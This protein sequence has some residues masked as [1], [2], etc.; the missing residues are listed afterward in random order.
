MKK[1]L[2]LICCILTVTFIL[3][4]QDKQ[5][6]TILHTNDLH[7]HLQGFAPESAYTPFTIQDDKTVGGFS[8]I[9]AIIKKERDQ[10]ISG[11]LVVD[12]GDCMM[13]TLFHTMEVYTGF[14]LQLM[15]K[16]GYD[17]VALG[18]HD[19]DF[20]PARYAR[21]VSV[22]A[23]EG[24]IPVLLL[25]NVITDPNDE[26]DDSFAELYKDGL[27]RHY[28]IVEKEGVK[29]GIFSIIGE[30]AKESAPFASPV[31]F[32]PA[33]SAARKITRD[34]KSLN[35]DV[36]ICLSHSGVTLDKKGNW[37]GE[38]VELAKKVKGI[39]LIISGH[40]HTTLSE[41]IN[42]NGI[43]IVQAGSAGRY[44]GKVELWWDGK[45]ASF[46]SYNL[47]PVTD[48]IAGDSEIQALI[49]EQEK[50]IDDQILKPSGLSYAMPIASVS[51][52]LTCDE[53]GDVASSNL[54][55]F[56]ADAI[57]NYVNTKGPG[58]DIAMTA[59]GVIRDQVSPGIQSVA[60]LFRVMSL[61]SGNDAIPG[62]PLSQLWVNGRELKNIAEV[63]IM[64]SSSTPSNFC[65]Y[66]HLNVIYNP[67]GGL[68]KKVSRLE[69][70][71]NN[72]NVNIID[73]SKDND[74]LYSIVANSYMLEFIGIIKKKSFGL[75][76]VVPKDKSGKPLSDMN[77]TVMD[78]DASKPGIQEG[79]EWLALVSYLS[80]MGKNDGNEIPEL[81]VYFKA[82][83]HSLNISGK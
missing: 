72:G 61:G 19:F 33:I 16:A 8:R 51:F 28:R 83:L 9:A 1:T 30:D 2:S 21:T 13:G 41:P 31:R 45:K 82:P 58:T 46:G 74:K 76:N 77:T 47:I 64:A 23:S 12:A 57:Y 81:P 5:K 7:S 79:K 34:L 10:N 70:T 32:S 80:Q 15:K 56:V 43:P 44:I 22:A 40:T 29:I 53:Y 39:D 65:Y 38:D 24:E 60:D 27:L 49:D 36:I 35:C 50:K 54:G 20:G 52:P 18:N 71:D 3:N 67:K 37:S 69:L 62:Y 66:S 78:F 11:T 14:Q 63:L 17:I 68:F 42:I 4:A 75:I 25:G 73:T 55:V 59:A 6:I 48:D 26:K